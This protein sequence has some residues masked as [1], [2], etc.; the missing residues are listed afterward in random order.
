MWSFD[1]TTGLGD[2]LAGAYLA[3]LQ[4]LLSL[5]SYQPADDDT[6]VQLMAAN[7]HTPQYA[8]EMNDISAVSTD[9]RLQM[10]Y[11]R[12]RMIELMRFIDTQIVVDD[13][14]GNELDIFEDLFFPNLAWILH[15]F[16]D[17]FKRSALAMGAPVPKHLFDRQIASV[18]NKW[19][20]VR[21]G[22]DSL[23][24]QNHAVD[25]FLPR[26]PPTD[27]VRVV[28]RKVPLP[29]EFHSFSLVRCLKPFQSI[30][31]PSKNFLLAVCARP[32]FCM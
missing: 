23:Q 19:N 13:G 28:R 29:C 8:L 25:S 27:N 15:S 18:A 7:G 4:N 17:Y 1:T 10:I 32:T 26:Y 30:R 22:L 14:R 6:R 11:A 21:E 20:L 16:R 31:R 12:G 5:D 24:L 2:V 9:Q 3:E